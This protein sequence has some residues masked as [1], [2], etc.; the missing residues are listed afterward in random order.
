MVYAGRYYLL[1]FGR[2]KKHVVGTLV[3]VLVETANLTQ[4][5]AHHRGHTGVE[6]L[7]LPCTCLL[8]VLQVLQ[9]EC[10]DPESLDEVDSSGKTLLDRLTMP[11]IF[12]DGY[13]QAHLH[14]LETITLTITTPRLT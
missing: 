4:I 6:N 12:P 10:V 2:N 13:E 14:S 9:Q 11:V 8:I 5:L 1:I 3:G 7:N